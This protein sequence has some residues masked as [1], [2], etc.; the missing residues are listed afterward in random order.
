MPA[1]R[2]LSVGQCA[3]D[4]GSISATFA[5]HFDAEVQP[6]HSSSDALTRLRQ[7]AFDLVLVNRLMDTDGASGIELIMQMKADEALRNIPVMLVSNYEDVQHDAVQAGAVPGFGK[8]ALGQPRMLER[9]SS[10][11]K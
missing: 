11:L 3:A 9:V 5:R 10:I 8:A 4:H 7:G 1:K 6:V 2:V